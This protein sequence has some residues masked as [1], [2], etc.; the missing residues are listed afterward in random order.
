MIL[1]SAGHIAKGRTTQP[2]FIYFQ[3]SIVLAAHEG[4]VGDE[5][6]DARHE[7]LYCFFNELEGFYVL[8][9]HV[10]KLSS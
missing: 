1:S 2:F 3:L 4:Y 5:L 8:E 6:L 10:Q 7:V 9:V